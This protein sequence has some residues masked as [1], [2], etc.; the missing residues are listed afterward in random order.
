M[1]KPKWRKYKGGYYKRGVLEV[2]RTR[3]GLWS[4]RADGA[5]LA[6]HETSEKA[7]KAADKWWELTL[8]RMEGK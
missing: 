7:M 8:E 2:Q 6:Y 1:K 5:R 4:A 3:D